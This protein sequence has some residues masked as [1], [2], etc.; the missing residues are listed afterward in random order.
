MFYGKWLKMGDDLTDAYTVRTKVFTEEQGFS[1]EDDRDETDKMAWHCVLVDEDGPFATGRIYY[2][3]MWRLGRI[4][5]LPEKR[6]QGFG[7]MVVRMLLDCA[8]QHHAP[9][10]GLHAQMQAVD[11]YKKYG[12]VQVGEPFDDAG[13]PHVEMQIDQETIENRVF[14]HHH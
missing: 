3:D 9:K 6:R 12:F 5:V 14:G 1:L 11:Y 13:K 8:M 4:C 7:D 2:Q 10:V